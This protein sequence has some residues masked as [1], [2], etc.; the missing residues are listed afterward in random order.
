MSSA[1]PPNASDTAPEEPRGTAARRARQQARGSAGRAPAPA[2]GGAS[3]ADAAP[4]R[5]ATS[6]PSAPRSELDP[7][8]LAALEEE[9]RF[10]LRSLDDLEREH[11]AGDVDELDY[12]ALR[13]DYTARAAG[14]IRAI[15]ERRSAIT[16]SRPPRRRGRTFAWVGA[17]LVLSVGLGVVVAQ[18]SGRRDPGESVSGDIRQTNRDLLLQAGSAAGDRRFVDAIALYDEVLANQ[19]ANT[20]ALTYK[21]W[22]LYLTSRSTDD[23]ADVEVL[24][25]RANDLLDQALAIDPEYGDARIFRATVLGGRGLPEQAIADLDAVRPGSVPEAMSGQI[26]SLRAQLQRSMNDAGASTT[27]PSG[28][29]PTG[30]RSP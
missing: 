5:P 25:S 12:A 13:D 11:D 14:V 30:Q 20:E 7:E 21:G 29:D 6:P 2:T 22:L 15:D 3:A 24:M 27:G 8:A 16:R 18:S 19:P 10:L 23:P 26:A 9:R 28:T 1:P 17:L 4:G